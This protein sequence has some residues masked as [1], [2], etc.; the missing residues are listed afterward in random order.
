MFI[1]Q[2]HLK[3][4]QGEFKEVHITVDKL[5]SNKLSPGDLKSEIQQLQS[6]KSQLKEKIDQLKKRTSTMP[7]FSEML[8]VRLIFLYIIIRSNRTHPSHFP[9]SPLILSHFS[10]LTFVGNYGLE[11]RTRGGKPDL[12]ASAGP[13]SS[14]S[15]L[16]ESATSCTEV[17]RG[18]ESTYK[19]WYPP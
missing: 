11:E 18:L 14:F 3:A 1:V 13:T 17:P 19:H 8:S 6:E 12:R 16:I 2:S 7:G 5:R 4:L 10:L 15:N 9:C